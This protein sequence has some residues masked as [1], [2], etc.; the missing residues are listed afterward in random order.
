[1]YLLTWPK[2]RPL[3]AADGVTLVAVIEPGRL[4]VETPAGELFVVTDADQLRAL[5][6]QLHAA[7]IERDQAVQHAAAK[8]SADRRQRRLLAGQ[9]VGDRSRR[10]TD[11]PEPPLHMEVPA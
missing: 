2:R 8:A 9:P 5:A 1:M 3:T 10:F 7:A 4:S 11:T 6:T